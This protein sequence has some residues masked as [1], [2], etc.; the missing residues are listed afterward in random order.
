[1]GGKEKVEKLEK[2]DLELYFNLIL[3]F[4]FIWSIGGNLYDG[5][6]QN[7]RQIYSQ[8]IKSKILKV[9]FYNYRFTLVSLSKVKYMITSSILKRKNSKTGMKLSLISLLIQQLLSSIF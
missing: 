9:I 7:S 6:P 8:F 3:I 2:N 4:S 1:L 5:M